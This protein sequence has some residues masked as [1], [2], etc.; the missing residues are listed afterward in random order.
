MFKKIFL[1]ISLLF[2]NVFAVSLFADTVEPNVYV[3]YFRYDG[4]YDAWDAWVWKRNANGSAIIPTTETISGQSW[5]TFDL[6]YS[7]YQINA[8]TEF[9]IIIRARNNWDGPREPGGDRYFRAGDG[10]VINGDYH[11][12]ILQSNTTIYTVK[13]DTFHTIL[14]ASFDDQDTIQFTTT[15]T[16]TLANIQ[17]I[18]GDVQVPVTNLKGSPTGYTVDTQTVDLT[19]PYTLRIV[20]GD[21]GTTASTRQ[22]TF[23][24]IYASD[25]FNSAYG[26]TGNDLGLTYTKKKSTFKLWA[27]ISDSVKLN[28]YDAGHPTSVRADGDDSATEFEMTRGDYG[29]WSVSISQDLAGKYYTYTI[30]NGNS[31]FEVVDPYAVSSGVNALRGAIIDLDKTNPTGW[32]KIE[33]PYFSGRFV[34]AILYELHVRDL[35]SHASWNGPSNYVG[36]FLGI[37]ET[38]TSFTKGDNTVKTGLDHMVEL[39]ITHLHLLPAFEFGYVDETR[40]DDPNYFKIKDGGFNWGY[41]PTLFNVPEG[42]YSTNPYDGSVRVN[43]FK[44]MVKSLAENGIRTVMDVVYNHTGDANYNFNKIVPNYFFRL[45]DTGALSNGSGTGNETASEHFMMRKFMVDSVVYWAKEYNVKGFRFDLMALHDVETMNQLT[46]ALH[47]IDPT[48]VVY[49]EPWTGGTTPLPASQQ[50]TK[51]TMDEMPNVAAF[52]DIVR[53][54]IRGNNNGEGQGWVQ[55]RNSSRADV[56]KGILGTQDTNYTFVSPNQT[57]NYVSAHDNSTLADQIKLTSTKTLAIR[58]L[59]QTQANAIVL[60]SQGV[61][62]IHAGAEMMRTKVDPAEDN[63]LNHN[64]YNASDLV[65]QMDYNWKI[66]HKT[67]FDQYVQLIELRKAQRSFKLN[68]YEEIN[69]KVEILNTGH[70]GVIAYRIVNDQSLYP[71][72]IVIHSNGTKSMHSMALPAGTDAFNKDGEPVWQIAFSNLGAETFNKAQIANGENVNVKPHETIILY[73]GQ[74]TDNTITIPKQQ[75]G[76]SPFAISLITGGS[77]LSI[78][79][80]IGLM[81]V[82]KK[83]KIA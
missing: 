8:D 50:A 2:L 42:S 59:M 12:Y 76:L 32:N 37:A 23:D 66:T 35:T 19:L 41:M 14:T 77:V 54:A 57:I 71:D 69:E 33:I 40:L 73:Y 1:L 48:I 52:N 70:D 25:F 28:V 64:S 21:N 31:T 36:K 61:P 26:Y 38:G 5:A 80:A 68:T 45:S 65:N 67:V 17:L 13:P 27:P 30:Q 51:E 15:T 63:G 3:H 47:D 75:S 78:G 60:T 4:A 55:G 16:V 34:D 49:G 56:I 6:P 7:T 44:V 82:F 18:K 22:V 74:N 72:M 24:G 10:H 9:G 62:F 39:G 53:N 11:F 29:V 79:A 43:E 46:E 83:K 81:F 58:K 20:F